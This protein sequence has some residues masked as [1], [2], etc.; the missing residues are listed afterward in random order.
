[1]QPNSDFSLNYKLIVLKV[2]DALLSHTATSREFVHTNSISASKI[3][4]KENRVSTTVKSVT[5]TRY[6]ASIDNGLN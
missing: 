2:Y 3:A 6:G 4:E 5:N 1:M